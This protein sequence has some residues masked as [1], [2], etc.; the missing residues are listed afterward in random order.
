MRKFKPGDKVKCIAHG[1]SGNHL[2]ENKIYTIYPI[3]D[4]GD[5]SH[6]PEGVCVKSDENIL[7]LF[8]PCRFVLIKE[9]EIDVMALDF[10]N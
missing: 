3:S 1:P 9:K 6:F 4:Y 2:T 7:E 5:N 8:Y 10:I